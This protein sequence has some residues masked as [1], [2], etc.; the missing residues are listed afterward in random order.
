METR[1][2]PQPVGAVAVE[3]LAQPGRGP[4]LQ[5]LLPWMLGMG[6]CVTSQMLV[7]LV[8]HHRVGLQV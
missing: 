5:A 4:G 2:G 6:F 1:Q 8:F 7:W 3:P